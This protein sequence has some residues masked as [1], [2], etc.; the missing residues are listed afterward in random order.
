MMT[1]KATNK[2]TANEL[3]GSREGQDG[4]EENPCLP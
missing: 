2:E 4:D 3:A 1:H